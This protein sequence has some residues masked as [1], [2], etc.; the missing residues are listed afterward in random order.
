MRRATT[1][2]YELRT[3]DRW[4]CTGIAEYYTETVT[5]TS[6][7]ATYEFGKGDDDEW[8]GPADSNELLMLIATRR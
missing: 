7:F 2:S 8:A 6:L 1:T 5:Y 4:T 3:F